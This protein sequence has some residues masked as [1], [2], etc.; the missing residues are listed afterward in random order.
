[1]ENKINEKYELDDNEYIFA[2][3]LKLLNGKSVYFTKII[4]EKLQR[5]VKQTESN[6]TMNSEWNPH[7]F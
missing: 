7:Y 3:I 5:K 4:V 1:M 6:A 2:E